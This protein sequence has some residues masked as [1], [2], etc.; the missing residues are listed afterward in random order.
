MRDSTYM[1]QDKISQELS[2]SSFEIMTKNSFP[3]I[4]INKLNLKIFKINIV[5]KKKKKKNSFPFTFS[6]SLLSSHPTDLP[7]QGPSLLGH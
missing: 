6:G 1:M 4:K 7:Y 5:E 2:W 3:P